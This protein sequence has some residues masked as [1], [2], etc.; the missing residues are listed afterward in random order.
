M[1]NGKKW[2]SLGALLVL[3]VAGSMWGYSRWQHSKVHI[4]TEDAYVKGNIIPVASKVPGTLVAV[5][6]KEFQDIQKGQLLV[7]LDPRDFDVAISR[8]EAS[9]AE[10]E[11]GVGTDRA[12]I[13]QG[14]AQLKAASSQLT[15]A[16]ADKERVSAL[17]QRESIPKQRLD[18]VVAQE[19]TSSAGVESAKKSVSAAKA[20]LVVS[21]RKV[22]VARAALE[23]AR[24]QR[25][26]CTIAAPAAG[27]ISKK[28]AEPGQVVAAGQPLCAIV[29][30]GIS[31]L[32]VEANFKETQLKEVRPGQRASVVSDVDRGKV[33]TG[34]VEGISAGTGAAFSLFPPE[35]ATG[36]WVKVVQRVPVKIRIDQGSDPNHQ[37]RLGL[38]LTVEIDTTSK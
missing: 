20:K 17:Y 32:W 8:A 1:A 10:A 25:S 27:Q 3:A 12:L 22:Q 26:Y 13:L 19:E 31:D 9:L 36:N 30:T 29:P 33:Y 35:N 14:E 6:F 5:G 16:R 18:Q 34:V 21:E 4:S 2:G 38:S 15:L 23:N 28:S 7:E 24:L 11:A 37:L